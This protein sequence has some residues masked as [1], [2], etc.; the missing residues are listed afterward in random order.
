MPKRFN[1]SE[2]D[3]EYIRKN[4]ANMSVTKI[5]Q[6][7]NLNPDS[8]KRFVKKDGL[9]G[10][11][12]AT[13]W[14]KERDNKLAEIYSDMTNEKIAEVMSMNIRAIQARAFILGLKKSEEHIERHR[15]GLFEHRHEPWNKGMKGLLIPGSEK[16]F[17]KKGN[18]PHNTKYDGAIS[19]R[20][21]SKTKNR[22]YYKRISLREWVPVHLLVWEEVNG[23]LPK[24]LVIRHINGDSLDNRIE[25]LE[26]ISHSEH[27]IKNSIHNY[28][29]EIK[30]TIKILSKL[31]KT[32]RNHGSEK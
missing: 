1:F 8:I 18:L 6:N 21:E 28:P 10:K 4:Y 11:S 32:I 5:A 27:M 3:K 17:F 23:K 26:A 19:L 14:T 22:Y 15:K 24:G 20:I 30:Q 2:S 12:R 9:T 7:L 31:N 25:N 29:E 13:V 16:G